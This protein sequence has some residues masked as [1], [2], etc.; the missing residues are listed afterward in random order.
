MNKIG[1][2]IA[3]VVV[4][5]LVGLFAMSTYN[6]LVTAEQAVEAQWGQVQNVYQRRAD[7]VPN[8]VA[9]VK[10]AA[11]FE[12][13]TLTQVIEAR[14]RVGQVSA[15][16]TQQ[17]LND[18]QKFQQ[19]QQAQDGLS[20][21]LSRLM[22][23]VERYPDLKAVAAFR[24]LMTQLEGTENRIAVE[25]R[26]FNQVAQDY[27]TRVRKF[28]AALFA[29]LFGFQPKPYFSAQAG[30]ETAPKVDFGGATPAPTPGR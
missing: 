4:I 17:I 16:A 7:L 23:V 8:L 3:A 12:Q 11:N 22:V 25:R 15:Q 13:S 29:G 26:A 21:A 27:N 19:F 20:S 10:G 30:A 24:D 6:G 5:V 1:C 14:S 18:P 2:L 9:S 28:P